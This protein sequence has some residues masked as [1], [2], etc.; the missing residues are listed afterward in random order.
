MI[1][2]PGALP[3]K[4]D[5]RTIHDKLNTDRDRYNTGRKLLCLPPMSNP[6][7]QFKQ[8]TIHQDRCAMKVCT[9][10]CVLGAW[11][12]QRIPHGVR[13]LD[14]GSGT[15]LL[16]LMLAQRHSGGIQGIELDAGAFG[17]LQ[18]NIEQSPW[19]SR[20]QVSFRGD[21]RAFAFPD[22]FGLYHRATRHFTKT[23]CRR[24]PG[25]KT[26]RSTGIAWP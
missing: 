21:V 20:L 17:Q 19:S 14:I 18:E 7:F 11:F 6:Y 3:E 10:A 16:I 12:S 23:I 5:I 4:G 15:G 24:P 8:F 22:T 25:Q 2:F 9:D 13:V 1:D 26:W